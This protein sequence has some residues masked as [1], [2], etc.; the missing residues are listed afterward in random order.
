MGL[1]PPIM[2]C[3]TGDGKEGKCVPFEE[4]FPLRHIVSDPERN[5]LNE[6]IRHYNIRSNTDGSH[7]VRGVKRLIKH[8]FFNIQSF[9]NDIA[10]LRLDR[11]VSFSNRIQPICLPPETRSNLVN[12]KLVVAGWGRV[13]YGGPTSPILQKVN[14]RVWPNS[15]CASVYKGIAPGGIL[16]TMICAG[17][18]GP[19]M[20]KTDT[21]IF[22]QTGIVS[23]G[24]GCGNSNNFMNLI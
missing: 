9:V 4:C 2:T 7:E 19:L 11:P 5:T 18:K 6:E 15:N 12:K 13:S 20:H 14:V 16:S 10:L 17:D 8:K 1:P 3:S 23:F 21:G 22:E 24:K